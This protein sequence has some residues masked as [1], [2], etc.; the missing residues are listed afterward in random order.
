VLTVS[1]MK[2]GAKAPDEQ[3][4]WGLIDPVSALEELEARLAD[5]KLVAT[6]KP[7][8]QSSSQPPAAK[9]APKPAA[10]TPVR[11]SR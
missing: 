3:F 9:P 4:G 11:A 7:A 2:L 8:P 1:A 6:A 10:P 5:N